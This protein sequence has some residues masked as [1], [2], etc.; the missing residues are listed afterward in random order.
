[1]GHGRKRGPDAVKTPRWRAERR[2]ASA[3]GRAHSQGSRAGRRAVPLGFTPGATR[4]PRPR[5]GTTAH[6]GPQ[7]TGAI[8]HVRCLTIASV[9][10]ASEHHTRPSFPRRRGVYNQL[11]DG[12]F[13]FFPWIRAVNRG[14]TGSIAGTVS[15][16]SS[17]G[18]PGPVANAT[19]SAYGGGPSNWYV[20]STGK[21]D[22][23]G[24]Y[25]LAY[26]L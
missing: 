7:R 25:R 10:G 14:A 2:R 16:D 9:S 15:N 13:D 18:T 23:A 26:L 21:T 22:A 1:M 11:G 12:A 8:P 19:V 3:N 17:V 5:R 4:R 20:L 6:P 24:H